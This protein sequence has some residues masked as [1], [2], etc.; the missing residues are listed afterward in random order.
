MAWT[1]KALEALTRTVHTQIDG[2][3]MPARPLRG[4]LTWRLKDAWLVLT[5]KADAVIWPGGQ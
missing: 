2:Q 5:G 4:P 1:L 3:W